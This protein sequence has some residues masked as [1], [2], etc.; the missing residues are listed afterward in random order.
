VGAGGMATVY[1]AR[2]ERL[3]RHVAVKVIAEPLSHDPVAVRRFH[4]EAEL[5]ARLAHPNIVA[6]LDAG[7][8]P[9]DF[10]VMEFVLGLDAGKLLKSSGRLT[11][12]QA[13]RVVAQ[14]CGALAHA[15]EQGVIHQDVTPYNIL[16]RQPDLG[17]KLVDFGLA[18]ELPD[19][20][21]ADVRGT[22][23]YIAPEVLRGAT[24]SA[25][26]DLYSLGMVAYRLL[27][28]PSS[29]R[30][31]DPGSTRPLGAA[32]ADRSPLADLRPGLPSVL[33]EAIE[34]ALADEPDE[35]QASVAEFS[36]QLVAGQNEPL[37]LLQLPS[38]A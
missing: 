17:A 11:P 33:T 4:R 5:A 26:S 12:G 23:G 2:D 10:I 19:V 36:A 1:R 13:V 29:A 15:H 9:H 31:G 3:N 35:R 27:T 30:R 34:Q 28:G 37:R 6:I 24:P 16:I 14:I 20:P 8:K 32:V 7:R 38:A 22:V 25:R 21:A 18:S